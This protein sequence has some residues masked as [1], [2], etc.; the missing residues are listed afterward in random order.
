MG[1]QKRGKGDNSLTGKGTA[2]GLN[3]ESPGICNKMYKL[4]RTCSYASTEGKQVKQQDYT[5]RITMGRPKQWSQALLVNYGME[6]QN[7]IPQT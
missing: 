1:W 3:R 4:C 6:H 5:E 7:N 2:M